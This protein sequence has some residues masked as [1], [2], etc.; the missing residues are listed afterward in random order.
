MDEEAAA[1]E[2]AEREADR[3]A[4]DMYA[5]RGQ[6][7]GLYKKDETS[8]PDEEPDV[9]E[10]DPYGESGL[11]IIRKENEARYAA[12]KQKE[13]QV[14]AAHAEPTKNLVRDKGARSLPRSQRT[15]ERSQEVDKSERHA[16]RKMLAEQ[17]YASDY[18]QPPKMSFVSLPS[19]TVQTRVD[20][21]W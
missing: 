13:E 14:Q 8:E 20:L 18:T 3:L 11:E 21:F 6:R 16:Y 17:S 9:P 15:A 5:K 10:Q 4:A 19:L 7:F 12:K 2:W 1:A